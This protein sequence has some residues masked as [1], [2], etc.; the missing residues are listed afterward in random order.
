MPPDEFMKRT[1]DEDEAFTFRRVETEAPSSKLE[2]VMTAAILR[3]AKEKFRTRRLDE[4]SPE[5]EEATV[6][7]EPLSQN[8]SRSNEHESEDEGAEDIDGVSTA[9]SKQAKGKKQ[10]K[11]FKPAIAT[12]DDLSYGLIQPSSRSILEKLDRT[13]TILHNARMTSAP[14]FLDSADPPSSEDES[15]Y[16]EA[17][18]SRR[19]RSRTASQVPERAHS[20]SR[21]RSHSTSRMSVTS[22]RPTSAKPKSTRG[23]KAQSKPREGESERE[24]LIRRAK[25]Q[26]KKL[27]VFSDDEAGGGTTTAPESA[28]SPRTPRRQRNR[29]GDGDHWMQKRL[30][31]LKLRDWSDIM[32]AAALAGFDPRIVERATQRCADLFGQGMDMHTV[33][34]TA[35]GSGDAGVETKRY[36]PGDAMPSSDSDTEDENESELRQSSSMSRLSSVAPS[37]VTSRATSRAASPGS[38]DGESH[39]RESPRKRQKRSRSRPLTPGPYYCPHANCDRAHRSFDR[40][41]NLRRHLRSVHREVSESEGEDEGSTGRAEKGELDGSRT[42]LHHCPHLDCARAYRGFDRP[43]NLKRHLKLVHGTEHV[44]EIKATKEEMDDFLGGVHRD[45]FLEPIRVQRGW[46]AEDTKERAKKKPT[47]KRRRDEGPDDDDEPVAGDGSSTA[48]PSGSEA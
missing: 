7:E 44:G 13:L 32:G 24:F 20:G 31:R 46:R 30:E 48:S 33:I 42:G 35:A 41:P 15:L 2:E 38:R 5:S 18:P 1:E 3:A 8:E 27:P 4:T 25:E 43:S 16:D 19:S 12:D 28:R 47:K 21:T 39:G 14:S 10:Q 17:A 34:E 6:K 37:K 26:K 23:R 22:D 40:W 36:L 45:G 11:S 9:R 29:T